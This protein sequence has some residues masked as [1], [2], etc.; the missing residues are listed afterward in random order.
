[1]AD[2]NIRPVRREDIA[3]IAAIYAGE[4]LHGIATFELDPPDVDEMTRRMEAIVAGGYPYLVAELDGEVAGSGY[5]SAYRS[6]PA[7]RWTVENS[8]YLAEHARGRG[9]GGTLLRHLIEDS[10]RLGFRQMVAVIS[11]TERVASIRLHRA[12]GF[13]E[14]GILRHVGFKHGRW[15]DTVIME[16]ALGDGASS[17]PDQT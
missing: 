6:R 17:P 10:E 14:V 7:Y 13:E 15:H 16:R 11:D 5:V 12:A 8:I 1:M 2:L 9:V 3:V 4:V